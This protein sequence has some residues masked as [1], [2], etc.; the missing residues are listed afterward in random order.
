MGVG[1][2]ANTASR[3]SQEASESGGFLGMLG[4]G[5]SKLDTFQA[6]L[7]SVLPSIPGQPAGKFQDIAIGIDMHPTIFP[8]SPVMAVPHVGMVFDILGAIFAAISAVVPPPPEPQVDDAGEPIPQP[9]S[10]SSVAVAI[11]QALKPSV[12]VNNKFI[13]NA[14]ISIQHL[15]GIILHALPSVSPMASSEMFMGS[16]TVLADGSPFSAQFLPALSCNLVGIPAPF[17]PKKAKPKVSLMAPTSSL[18]TVI[19]GGKPVLVGGPPT[20]DLFALAI[21]LGLKGLGKLW[22]KG[23]DKFQKY[24]DDLAPKNPSKAARLQPFKCKMFGEPVDAATGRVFAENTD[25]TIPG[26][27][28]ISWNRIYHSDGEVESPIGSNWHHSYYIGYWEMENDLITILLPD[29]R[30]IVVPPLHPGDR[31]YHRRE[32]ITWIRNAEGYAYRDADGLTYHFSTFGHGDRFHPIEKI[33]DDLG[34]QIQFQYTHTGV[35]KQIIDSAGR[36]FTVESN[37][38]QR[39]TGVWTGNKNKKTYLIRYEVDKNDNLIKV[40]DANDVSKHF[41]YEGHL[42]VRL[43]NQSELNFYWEY[44]GKGDHAKCIH[45]W[46]DDGILE[47]WTQYEKGK[48]ISTNSLGHTTTYYYDEKNLIYRITDA[49]QGETYQ[50]YN[51]YQDLIMVTDPLGYAA[52]YEYD[53]SGNLI[54]ILNPNGDKTLFEYTEDHKIKSYRSPGGA[55]AAWKYDEEGKLIRRRYADGT[56]AA[57]TYE[58]PRLKSIKDQEG[59]IT[60]MHWGMQET[61]QRVSLDDGRSI[62]WIYDE[63]GQVIRHIDIKGNTTTY[64]YDPMGNVIKL[65]EADG[66]LH[67]FIY[68]ASGNVIEAK[69][70]KRQVS[71]TYWGLGNLKS[72]T[73]NGKTIE[74]QYNTEEQLQ[75]IV[76][77][78]NEVYR[79]TLD[80]MGQIIGEWGFDG[81]QRRY[82]RDRA[83]RVVKVLRPDERWTRYMYNGTGN[84]LTADHYDG[85]GEYFTYDGDGKLIEATNAFNTIKLSYDKGRVTEEIQND[86]AV[87]STYDRSGNRIQIQ[88]SLG[89]DITH[90]FIKSGELIRTATDGWEAN[91]ERDDMGLEIRR[92]V[93]GGIDMTTKRDRFGRVTKHSIRTKNIEGR[94]MAYRWG[95]NDELSNKVDELRSKKTAFTYDETGNLQ[96]ATYNNGWE[97]I[98][99]MPDAV[100]NLFKTKSRNDRTYDTGGKLKKD[101]KASY[102][103]D[104]EGN[105]IS[106][107]VSVADNNKDTGEW[108]YEWYGNGML[109]TVR[110]PAKKQITFEYD[111]LGRRT[112]KIVENHRR[113][114]LSGGETPKETRGLVTRWVWDGNVP[115]HE[116]IYDLNDRP[117][118]YVD[119]F[120]EVKSDE[121][122]PTDSTNQITWLFESDSF[123]PAAKMVGD[124]RYSIAC[125]YLGTPVQAYDEKG[126]KVWDCELDIY[127][128]V[129][130]IEGDKTFIPF[131]Y[132]GQYEDAETGLYYNRFRYYSAESGTYISQDKLRL[133]G[134]SKLYEYSSNTTLILDPFGLMDFYHATNGS[135][136]T[137]AVMGGIDPSKGRP[138]LDFNPSGQGGFYVTNDLEQAQSWANRKG[139]D[140]IHF[141]VP[142]DE[143]AKL[144]I[145]TFDGATQEWAD[146]VTS[147][148]KGTLSHTFDGV[149]GPMLANP[150]GGK[151]KAIGHQ[152]AIFTDE[153]AELFDK[154]N[155]GKIKGSH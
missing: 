98:Y 120:G 126:I 82:I 4:E 140:V 150:R 124:K 92:M 12:L 128:N 11:V 38:Q 112:A 88:S 66:N 108:T 135:S 37:D 129:R 102:T 154:H 103:Y 40:T 145:K 111:A 93:S 39:I 49:K 116:W 85:T 147:G 33:T 119:P 20:I 7:A 70:K 125:D 9:V 142:D 10:V 144:N 24:I 96:T 50:E 106:K 117:S 152:L 41:Y 54:A 14:G 136:S 22:K 101:D 123:V 34:Y 35:L 105:L 134:G 100:G 59:L 43:T 146:T 115:L 84:I 155:K 149:D 56:T 46:G 104:A 132:Q 73:E 45:T 19:P 81:L 78:E 15:P 121:K 71:F 29:S 122:E 113:F 48:T 80:A 5:K 79:F 153:A 141:D 25:F 131:R 55:T 18:L 61:L 3:G 32:K 63:L 53:R 31:F 151:P 114:S 6:N 99:K 143:L 138:N 137:D 90:D 118:L 1:N 65:I 68:D 51:E 47:Y 139:G 127:G 30:E 110:T 76:N 27:I 148:R 60:T 87:E 97:T 109:K 26:P 95:R 130:S 62:Q 75:S 44:E 57:Y 72:R 64:E 2:A 28:P 133:S 91:F 52:K 13:A 74:F 107:F 8:P 89:A 67:H 83:G 94:R 36:I 17:R 58:G 16:A 21:N 77:E 69:D 42:L 23:G 86:Y